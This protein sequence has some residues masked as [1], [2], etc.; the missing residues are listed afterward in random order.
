MIIRELVKKI[1]GY[2]YVRWFYHKY[3]DQILASKST[4]EVFTDIFTN[5]K[6]GGSESV[7]GR[8]SDLDHSGVKIMIDRLPF[9]FSEFKIKSILGIPCGDFNWMKN[10]KM[11]E[12]DY[13]GADIV[14]ELIQQN[15]Q[16]FTGEGRHFSKLNLI[17][18]SLP[19]VDLIFC[20]DCLIHFS[21]EDIF[22]ALKNICN[23][24]STYLMATTFTDRQHNSDIVTGLWQPLN[25][26]I[27]PLMF[28]S[29]LKIIN[30]EYKEYDE[31]YR[32]KSLGLYK[33]ADIRANL[34]EMGKI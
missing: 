31:I 22:L 2:N 12:I 25:L 21:F 16:K 18:D 32:D 8:G 33:I 3:R 20:R 13:T 29:A 34:I 11:Q 6:W 7:S 10:V 27:D 28:P 19:K 24:E 30:E 5:N 17:N 1:P 26:E 4:E 9:V 14:F 23:S 15:R